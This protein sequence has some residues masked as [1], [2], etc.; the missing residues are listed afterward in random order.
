MAMKIIEHIKPGVMKC[1][2][3]EG[4][5]AVPKKVKQKCRGERRKE[6]AIGAAGQFYKC[7]YARMLLRYWW[8]AASDSRSRFETR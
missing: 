1:M 5:A 2:N 7:H 4:C 6:V 8:L 3:G